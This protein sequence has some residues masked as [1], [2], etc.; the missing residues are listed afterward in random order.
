MDVNKFIMGAA[1]FILVVLL[2]FSILGSLAPEIEDSAESISYPNNCSV[3][4][5]PNGTDF[6]YYDI[7]SD[8]CLNN[9]AAPC[10]NRSAAQTENRLP[11]YALFTPGGAA[12][13]IL[14]AGLFIW[15]VVITIKKKS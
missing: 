2:F 14:M 5:D 9:S 6:C 13:V 3:I 15:L 1:G 7:T 8:R 4:V 11:L 12:M 10:Y